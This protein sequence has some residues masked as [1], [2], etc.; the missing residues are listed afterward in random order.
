MDQTNA[1]IAADNDE[2]WTYLSAHFPTSNKFS[3]LENAYCGMLAHPV[4]NALQR[5]QT[6]I[7]SETSYFL[8]TKLKDKLLDVKHMLAEFCGVDSSELLITRNLTEAIYI[9]LRRSFKRT[10]HSSI[11]RWSIRFLPILEK[12]FR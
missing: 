4:F 8:R 5:Y 2:Y 7:N 1:D 6:E 3:N 9:V 12:V 11:N 10:H